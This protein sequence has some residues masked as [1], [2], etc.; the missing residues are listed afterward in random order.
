VLLPPLARARPETARKK[1]FSLF[2]PL[3]K[4][5]GLRDFFLSSF[6]FLGLQ[7][8]KK[9]G[10]MDSQGDDQKDKIQAA[11]FQAQNNV[12]RL[13]EEMTLNLSDIAF[14][15]SYLCRSF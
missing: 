12:D 2:L 10:R 8:G 4:W 13:R 14:L 3:A 9:K 7:R 6:L 15:S 5:A 11:M 1:A